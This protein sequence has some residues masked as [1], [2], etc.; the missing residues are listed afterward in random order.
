MLAAGKQLSNNGS[1]VLKKP[2]LLA[3]GF[4]VSSGFILLVEEVQ[5]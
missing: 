4:R 5:P 2:N 1:A 3:A